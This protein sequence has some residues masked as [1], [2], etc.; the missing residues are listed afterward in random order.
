MLFQ[1]HRYSRT[2]DLFD[3]FVKVLSKVDILL[4]LNVYPAGEAALP[5]ADSRALAKSI[6]QRGKVD[7]I[8]IE[9]K[10]VTF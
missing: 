9:D 8:L 3:G 1:P 5:D 7:P 4:L 2:R 6:R 10:Q